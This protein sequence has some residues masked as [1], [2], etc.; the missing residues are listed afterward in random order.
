MVTALKEL[1]EILDGTLDIWRMEQGG[2]P[3]RK[4]SFD[5][6]ELTAGIKPAFQ[7]KAGARR[8]QL[9]FCASS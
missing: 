8:I 5:W 4:E 3:L 7:V 1:K 6:Q 9:T 2:M